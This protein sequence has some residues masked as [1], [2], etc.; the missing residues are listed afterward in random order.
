LGA[1]NLNSI[2]VGTKGLFSPSNNHVPQKVYRCSY[3]QEVK[4]YGVTTSLPT[5]PTKQ[6]RLTQFSFSQCKQTLFSCPVIDKFGL[7][8]SSLVG[9]LVWVHS[10][11]LFLK[12]V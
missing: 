4:K 1:V 6:S 3:K 8:T 11:Q 7:I 5:K 10:P 12:W 2:N 9:R